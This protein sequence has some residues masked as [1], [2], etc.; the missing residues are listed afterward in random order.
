MGYLVNFMACLFVAVLVTS[1]FTLFS[2]GILKDTRVPTGSSG[3]LRAPIASAHLGLLAKLK[4]AR[5]SAPESRRSWSL[6]RHVKTI[7]EQT[8]VKAIPC[9]RGLGVTQTIL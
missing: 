7:E 2:A 6:A 4:A 1:Y 3:S 5:L 8:G 9:I